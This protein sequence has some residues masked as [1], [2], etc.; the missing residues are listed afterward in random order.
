M[1]GVDV[2]PTF[3]VSTANVANAQKGGLPR[4]TYRRDLRPKGAPV[5]VARQNIAKEGSPDNSRT[6][7]TGLDLRL[8][9][10]VGLEMQA[11]SALES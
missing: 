10:L 2:E 5:E 6:R 3:R 4:Y 7:D 1:A 8:D 9:P 11:S